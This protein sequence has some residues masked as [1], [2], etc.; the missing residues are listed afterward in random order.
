MLIQA[1][2]DYLRERAGE[3]ERWRKMFV[4]IQ[5]EIHRSLGPVSTV[6][7][8]LGW[9]CH[10]W[11]EPLFLSS[12]RIALAVGAAV[13]LHVN[14]LHTIKYIFTAESRASKKRQKDSR[15]LE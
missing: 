6:T 3:R 5:R 12:D 9:Y 2:E 7:R 1:E 14:T 15:Q 13:V 8:P 4:R 10:K 11:M